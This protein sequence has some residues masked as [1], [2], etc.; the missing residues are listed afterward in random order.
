MT[1]MAA[2]IAFG[3]DF[4]TVQGDIGRMNTLFK[5]YLEVWVLLAIAAAYLLW[6]LGTSWLPQIRPAI[7]AAWLTVLALLIGASLI[8]TA[9]GARDRLADRF[10]DLPPTLDGAAYMT[11]ARHWERD[12]IF[13]LVW[14]YHAI[15]WLQDNAEGSPVV[16]E[17]HMEQ[18][19]WGAR[20]AKYTGLPTILGWPWHQ[21][22]QRYAYRDQV[23]QRARDIRRA[24]ETVDPGTALAILQRYG[25]TYI[26]VGQLERLNY[27]AAGLA[28]FE[29]MA[30]AGILRKVYDHG[31]TAIFQ[32]KIPQIP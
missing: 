30:Q 27:P 1:A 3:V 2:L 22:Q 23:D 13:P 24:Y 28:K 17:A 4:V 18:Y 20:I 25:V 14:D 10:A 16:L 15:R 5:Y 12:T 32:S 8:Y 26:I 21:T 31:E 7:A 6:R 9:L 29:A 11:A 19:R